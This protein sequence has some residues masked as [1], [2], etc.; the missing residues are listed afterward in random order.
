MRKRTQ[1]RQTRDRHTRDQH[2]QNP[3]VEWP[4]LGLIALCYGVWALG[5]VIWWP[6]GMICVALAVALHSSLQHE[7]IH[8]HPTASD[9]LNA[10]LVFPALG[11]LIPFGRFR[12]THLAHHWDADLTDPYDDP[13]SNYLDPKIWRRLP[14]WTQAILRFNNT[15]AGRVLVGAIIGQIA[16]L[17]K[18]WAGRRDPMIWRAWVWHIPAVA[19]VLAWVLWSGMPVLAYLGGA[20]IGLSLIKIRTF[21][22]HQAHS[23]VLG[24][25]AIVEDRGVL[26]FLFLNNNLHLV[27]HMHPKMPWYRLPAVYQANKARYLA[28]N[29]AYVFTSYRQILATYLLRCKDSVPH[30]F[31]R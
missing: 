2:G 21:L 5:T 6:V 8:G 30:P 4:T 28:R 17:R 31:W 7:V 20:Y 1:D 29:R 19:L 23:H 11:L 3:R 27:H 26:A 22:E 15:L 14:G 18:D 16:F 25:T 10:A 12:D 13:E 24:R 9:R